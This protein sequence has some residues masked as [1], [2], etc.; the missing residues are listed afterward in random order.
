[1]TSNKHHQQ[2]IKPG[3][4]CLHGKRLILLGHGDIPTEFTQNETYPWHVSTDSMC[5]LKCRHLEHKSSPV[6]TTS[7]IEHRGWIS[8]ETEYCESRDQS[9]TNHSLL[10][11]H[12]SKLQ[13]EQWSVCT[14]P[15]FSS[16]LKWNPEQ[17]EFHQRRHSRRCT[18]PTART[19][20]IHPVYLPFSVLYVKSTDS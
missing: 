15:W 7:L 5:V 17:H 13:R 2:K 16:F 19:R 12:T 9:D 1:M 6:F 20:H 10:P 14:F 4:W 18:Q 3:P 11:Q 8:A